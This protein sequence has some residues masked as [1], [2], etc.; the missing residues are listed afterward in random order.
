MY[1]TIQYVK[2]TFLHRKRMTSSRK[3]HLKSLC[4]SIA[5][6]FLAA[7]KKESMQEKEDFMAQIPIMDLSGNQAALVVPYCLLI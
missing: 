6:T 3:H 2:L 7:E 4:L 1:I 5:A